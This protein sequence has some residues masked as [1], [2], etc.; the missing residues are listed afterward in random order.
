MFPQTKDLGPIIRQ[1]RDPNYKLNLNRKSAKPV[2]ES[3]QQ[4][5]PSTHTP[6]H[7]PFRYPGFVS[8]ISPSTGSA[9]TS[10][11]MGRFTTRRGSRIASTW[12]P[13][14]P[15]FTQSSIKAVH[16]SKL[17][18]CRRCACLRRRD[19]PPHSDIS[20]GAMTT[21]VIRRLSPSVSH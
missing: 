9:D 3:S 16:A 19:P 6:S 14:L 21:I 2:S 5:G 8:D 7:E 11:S 13:C 15:N 10:T 12:C 18:L 4:A 20:P 1:S 17:Q